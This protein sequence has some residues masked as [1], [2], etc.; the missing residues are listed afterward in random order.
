MAVALLDYNMGNLGS[1]QK[2]LKF[3]DAEVEVVESAAQLERF[4]C[5]ILPGVGNFGDGMEHLRSRGFDRAIPALLN[6]GGYFF[7][8]CLGM[9][10]LLEASDEAPGVS[11]LG[12]FK[13]QVTRFPEGRQKV[14]HMGWNSVVFEPNCPLGDGLPEE[15][16]F[17]FVHSYYVPI[18]AEYTAAKCEYIVPFSACIGDNRCFAAQFHPEKS[19]R[20]GLRMLSNFLSLAG[21]VK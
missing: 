19:Q 5:C 11:G 2:A 16:F 10:M 13:G 1:V 21:E 9:Q 20:A 14:P 4:N 15:S 18:S 12:I 17:Y 8:V 6:R 3:V 7:G